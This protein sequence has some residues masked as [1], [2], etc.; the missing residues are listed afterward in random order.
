MP[1]F[2]VTGSQNSGLHACP[3][4]V[5]THRAIFSATF[6]R[7]FYVFP[8]SHVFAIIHALYSFVKVK[9]FV[10]D[11]KFP[12]AGARCLAWSV[13]ALFPWAEGLLVIHAWSLWMT[14]SLH[15]TARQI[16]LLGIELSTDSSFLILYFIVGTPLS[17]SWHC[18]VKSHLPFLAPYTVASPSSLRSVTSSLVLTHMMGTCPGVFLFVSCEYTK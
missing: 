4:G 18:S 8:V 5:L 16:F 10:W 11:Y 12:S 7:R 14:E 15:C 3:A 6:K 9:I 1:S 2:T 17:S 13:S